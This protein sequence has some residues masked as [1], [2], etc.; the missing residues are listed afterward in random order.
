MKTKSTLLIFSLASLWILSGCSLDQKYGKLWVGGPVSQNVTI[1]RLYENSEN[2]VI[3]YAGPSVGS[4]AAI[5]FDPK[6]DERKIE[7]HEYWAR[8]KDRDELLDL[9]H[10]VGMR[11]PIIKKVLG[12]DDR[13]YGYI[14]IAKAHVLIRVIDE[15][16][17]WI[18]D[19][20]EDF[21]FMPVQRQ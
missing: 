21:F 6:S 12:P 3:H 16:T 14:Y 7:T 18:D 2:Y 15:K 11:Q 8:V 20:W 10:F 17:L 9:I 19:I 5:L 13:L 1:D 4:A